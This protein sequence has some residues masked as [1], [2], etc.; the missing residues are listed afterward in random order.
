[1]FRNKLTLAYVCLVGLPL[2]GLIGILDA[3]RNLT[4]PTSLAGAWELEADLSAIPKGPCGDLFLA[5]SQPP[6]NIS[7]SGKRLVVALNDRRKTSLPGVVEGD[8][9][10]I[11]TP[12]SQPAN[13]ANTPCNAQ[14]P[15]YARGRVTGDIGRRS[16]TGSLYVNSC[17]HCPPVPF[18]A[19]QV[20]ARKGAR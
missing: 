8:E 11:G 10:T 3:G 18:R 16:L 2:L 7:Q 9:V 5:G 14:E 17:G 13:V 19:S 15:F 6:L 20:F 12:R 1:M 4:A